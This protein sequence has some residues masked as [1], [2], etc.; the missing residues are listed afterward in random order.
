MGDYRDFYSVRGKNKRV[1]VLV[2]Y[3]SGR[4]EKHDY[5]T[6]PAAKRAIDKFIK[7]GVVK[8]AEIRRS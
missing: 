2:K 7:T 1:N 6:V 8:C 3:K 5:G 4:Q